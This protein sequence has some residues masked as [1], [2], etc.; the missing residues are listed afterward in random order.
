MWQGQDLE[1]RL[2]G[3]RGHVNNCQAPWCS[4]LMS[5]MKAAHDGEMGPRGWNMFMGKG[6]RCRLRES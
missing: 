6:F 3:S 1:P 2:S 5:F 4:V